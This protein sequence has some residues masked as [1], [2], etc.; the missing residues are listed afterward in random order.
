MCKGS[1]FATQIGQVSEAGI[2]G[3]Y[4]LSFGEGTWG[5]RGSGRVRG[6]HTTMGTA[7]DCST[8]RLYTGEFVRW[9]SSHRRGLVVLSGLLIGHLDRSGLFGGAR[10]PVGRSMRAKSQESCQ[11]IRVQGVSQGE[12]KEDARRRKHEAEHAASYQLC[13]QPTTSAH[14]HC[15]LNCLNCVH[16][17]TPK[18]PRPVFRQRRQ[19]K[20]QARRTRVA[21]VVLR[22]VVHRSYILGKV[23]HPVK[24][25][26]LG[27]ERGRGDWSGARLA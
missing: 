6:S 18:L 4:Q 27:G 8:R 15:C 5:T 19:A 21:R 7:R 1:A 17:A 10:S 23:V 11:A 22:C 25:V 14:V 9:P 12:R 16:V 13:Y 24:C 3:R 2:R 20:E 26:G